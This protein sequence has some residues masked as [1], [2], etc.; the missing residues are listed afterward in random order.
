MGGGEA[1]HPWKYPG[2]NF[3]RHEK[4]QSKNV[5]TLAWIF[6]EW[7][8][9]WEAKFLLNK[10]WG[11]QFWA[12][13]SGALWQE[14]QFFAIIFWQETWRRCIWEQIVCS[15]QRTSVRVPRGPIFTGCENPV[16]PCKCDE[17]QPG[18]AMLRLWDSEMIM[19]WVF[20]F[21]LRFEEREQGT[22]EQREQGETL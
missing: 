15:S 17:V 2:Y 7:C 22:L 1:A 19:R 13:L 16:L 21:F 4:N 18:R 9:H 6:I 14:T 8:F 5:K 10:I 12:L 11:P 20:L 3:A